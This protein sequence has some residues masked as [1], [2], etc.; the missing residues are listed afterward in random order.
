MKHHK[1]I[2]YF[3]A[4][5][6][7]VGC[8][9]AQNGVKHSSKKKPKRI[10]FLIGDGMGLTQI[11]T[12][13][14]EKDNTSNFKRFKSIGFINTRSAS[15]KIT[16]SA[17]G[18]TAFACGEKTY[19]NSVGMNVDTTAI[20]NLVELYSQRGYETG[21]ISTSAITH[22]TPAAF[23]AHANHRSQGY[24]IAKQLV[25]SDVDFFAGGGRQF[26]RDQFPNFQLFNWNIDTTT[27]TSSSFSNLDVTKKYGYLFEDDGL[28]TMEASRGD[29]LPSAASAAINYFKDK[30]SFI[31][32]EGSQIDWGGHANDYAYVFTEMQDFD[33]TIGMILDYA[34]KDG[35]TLV[36][37]TADH[38]TGGLSL[39]GKPYVNKD[40]NTRQNYDEIDP[41]FTTGGHTAAL[42][43]VFAYGP[44]AENFQGFYENNE[45]FHK[46]KNLMK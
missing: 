1:S 31:M 24:E 35:N 12:M 34:E 23:Y 32:I 14:L 9:S 26:F 28:K 42:I 38:E 20:P 10:I 30:K 13:F 37:V 44:G 3:L 45:I 8:N 19:N 33:K 7:A 40:G 16:D 6:L 41:A 17:A 21:L 29:F 18:A 43:P 4:L 15:H 11:S 2:F 36:V 46:F 39:Q 27:F 5:V 25:K 22:A